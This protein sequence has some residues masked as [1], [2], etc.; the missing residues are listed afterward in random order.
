M[1]EARYRA[2]GLDAAWRLLAELAWLA[3]TGC[4]VLVSRLEDASLDALRRQ[5]DAEFVGTGEITDFAW[6]PAWLLTVKPGLADPLREAQLSRHVDPH[7]AAP[8]LCQILTLPRTA[9][10]PSLLHPR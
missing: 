7:R 1:T 10:P 6:F 5:F 8:T 3:P 9:R 4:V 2:D